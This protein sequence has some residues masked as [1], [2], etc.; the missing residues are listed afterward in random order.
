METIE[1]PAEK[2]MAF[3]GKYLLDFQVPEIG[4]YF[5][6]VT[7]KDNKLVVYDP[8]NSETNILTA[9]EELKFIDLNTGDNIEIKVSE[10]TGK[11]NMVFNNRFSF[12]KIE[13]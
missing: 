1:I 13:E 11:V 6:E 7:I 10:D 9:L 3:A 8:N 2:L 12:N 4:D 5:I